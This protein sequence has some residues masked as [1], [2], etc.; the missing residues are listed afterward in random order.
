M[1]RW[2]GITR[3]TP[4]V[5]IVLSRSGGKISLFKEGRIFGNITVKE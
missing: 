2:Q 4:A 3:D 1:H 5:G